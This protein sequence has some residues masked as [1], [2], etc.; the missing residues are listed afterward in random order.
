[1][2][3]P[4]FRIATLGCKANQY[5]SQRLAEA[6]TA[7]GFHEAGDSAPPSV[8]V[9]NTCTVTQ[10]ADRKS[11][12]LASRALREHPG[13]RVFVTG[14]YAT[15]QPEALRGMDGV[16]GVFGR[17]EWNEMLE[18]VAGASLPEAVRLRGDFGIAGFRGRTR[19]LL[20]VQE[21][22]DFGCAYCVVPRVRGRPR[23]RP[24]SDVLSEARRLL[25]CGFREIV[26]TGIHLGLYGRDMGEGVE[27]AD[28]VEQV[29]SLPGLGRLRLSSLEAPELSERLLR[30][31]K[32]PAVCAHLHL[33]LQSG[34]DG[35][36]S[37]MKRRYT[38]GEFLATV[39][40]ARAHL[41]RPAITGDVIVGFPGETHDD[42]ENTLRTCQD[43]GFTR[44]H[45]FPFSPRPGTVAA[46]LGGTV[47]MAVVRER[48][49][50]LK[51]LADALAVQW[52]RSFVGQR[53][54]AL[55]EDAR[56]GGELV[57]YTDRYVRLSVR[58]DAKHLGE[59]REVM[60][61]RAWGQSLVGELIAEGSSAE[62]RRDEVV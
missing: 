52:A 54:R 17:Q 46:K 40:A 14:C 39:D 27:L 9:I 53:E 26:L 15:A 30:A 56:L 59:L 7:L 38:A 44:L 45:V 2:R 51:D 32:H 36:L 29:A 28:A 20:K 35:V 34:D 18:A 49:A 31:M 25:D 4:T 13:S 8:L 48:C 12:Q 41:D 16:S 58:C 47:Q 5:D 3:V 22:C 24:L 1:M 57:G 55:L 23:S 19:A 6:L 60:C 50:R 21:G 10:A 42:F 61:I 62:A 37:R 33:P 43:V 11:R